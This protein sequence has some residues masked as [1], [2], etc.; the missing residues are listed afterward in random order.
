M[1]IDNKTLQDW[2]DKLA[3]MLCM[4][5]GLKIGIDMN[6]NGNKD[7]RAAILKLYGVQYQNLM[8]MKDAIRKQQGD[9]IIVNVVK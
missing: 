2:N 8:Q 1:S 5:E 9:K 3:D 7:A 4:L 6:P